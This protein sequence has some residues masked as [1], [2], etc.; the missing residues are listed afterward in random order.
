MVH[1][2]CLLTYPHIS[3]NRGE[4]NYTLCPSEAG[5]SLSNSHKSG[6]KP[7]S[8]LQYIIQYG[9]ILASDECKGIYQ[10]LR[11]IRGRKSKGLQKEYFKAISIEQC[12]LT[13]FQ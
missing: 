11:M 7:M 6:D 12:T 1:E 13:T 10:F 3:T 8:L 2:S 4:L 9:N 5:F